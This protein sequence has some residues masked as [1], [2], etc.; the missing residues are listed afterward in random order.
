MRAVLDTNTI[1]SAL[2]WGG[3]PWKV[4]ATAFDGKYIMLTTEDLFNEFERVIRRPKFTSSLATIQKT[5]DELL[6]DYRVLVQGVN[7]VEIPHNT[8]RDPQDQAVLA[9][10]VGGNA[11]FVVSGDKDL[12]V[13]NPYQNILIVS[14]AEFLQQLPQG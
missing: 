2:F 3:V 8:V 12:L 4:Y 5:A 13:L 14:A 9:C 11:D 6:N 10:A 1:I 7:P